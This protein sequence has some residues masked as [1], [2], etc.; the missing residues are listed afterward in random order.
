MIQIAPRTPTSTSASTLDFGQLRR[1]DSPPSAAVPQHAGR[2]PSPTRSRGTQ[3]TLSAQTKLPLPSEREREAY[4]CSERLPS[5]C[6]DFCRTWP[7]PPVGDIRST[8]PGQAR[9]EN[10]VLTGSTV[11][12]T[13]PQNSFFSTPIHRLHTVSTSF[14]Q[15]IQDEAQFHTPC[16]AHRPP[17][18]VHRSVKA[19]SVRRIWGQVSLVIRS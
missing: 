14:T 13:T 19:D 15:G 5:F 6:P 16:L 4:T 10:V 17:R 18:I 11:V 9:F 2:I 7:R 8:S 3:Q 12:P 1:V